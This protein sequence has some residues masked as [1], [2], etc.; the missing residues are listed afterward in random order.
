MGEER[1]QVRGEPCERHH[2]GTYGDLRQP[3]RRSR[4]IGTISRR[5]RHAADC[6]LHPWSLTRDDS[7]DPGRARRVGWLW[8][9]PM[10]L[11]R[12]TSMH[13]DALNRGIPARRVAEMPLDC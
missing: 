5:R 7:A 9:E 3:E 11:A 12:E 2:G 6:V 13:T 1:S 4:T 8:R 10:H